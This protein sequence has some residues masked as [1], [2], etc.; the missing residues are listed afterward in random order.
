M[1]L[2]FRDGR[3]YNDFLKDSMMTCLIFPFVKIT[4]NYV[5]SKYEVKKITMVP[6]DSQ[7]EAIIS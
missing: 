6:R 3:F 7:R 2:S 4:E 5:S 1:W